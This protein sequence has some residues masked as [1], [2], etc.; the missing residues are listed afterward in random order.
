MVSKDERSGKL[1]TDAH[2]WVPAPIGQ[3]A[4]ASVAELEPLAQASLRELPRG[5]LLSEKSVSGQPARVC[6]RLDVGDAGA[7]RSLSGMVYFSRARRN[8]VDSP[9]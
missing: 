4:G 2:F 7:E 9:H 8:D 3:S 5:F 1:G 6:S